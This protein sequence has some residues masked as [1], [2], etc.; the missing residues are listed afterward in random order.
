MQCQLLQ[1]LELL[2]LAH[3]NLSLFP[4]F[5]EARACNYYQEF[6]KYYHQYDVDK[7]VYLILL[8][9]IKIKIA[10]FAYPPMNLNIAETFLLMDHREKRFNRCCY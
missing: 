6:S 4:I 3:L 9:V 2:L 8:N 5:L 1:P 7:S 10:K